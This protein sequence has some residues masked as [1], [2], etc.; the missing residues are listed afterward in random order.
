[1]LLSMLAVSVYD[2]SPEEGGIPKP[3]KLV[4]QEQKQSGTITKKEG[5]LLVSKRT[6]FWI[7]WEKKWAFISGEWL[8]FTESEDSDSTSQTV[9]LHSLKRF[10]SPTFTTFLLS[11][12]NELRTIRIRVPSPQADPSQVSFELILENSTVS[13]QGLTTESRDDWVKGFE[14]SLSSFVSPADPHLPKNT[15]ELGQLSGCQVV[16]ESPFL[17]MQASDQNLLKK[18]SE[19]HNKVEIYSEGFWGRG[20]WTERYVSIEENTL[21]IF[22]SEKDFRTS[23]PPLE[24]FHLKNLC[25]GFFFCLEQ[26]NWFPT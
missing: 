1:M 22:S 2:V 9:P 21:S 19:F 17:S 4:E 20:V 15:K 16:A 25:F 18:K 14:F 6:L 3:A 5:L 8:H 10:S 13:L 11:V 26:A 7:T 12:F 24:R 23:A